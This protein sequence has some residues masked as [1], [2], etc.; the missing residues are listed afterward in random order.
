MRF[1]VLLAGYL[2]SS[3]I[4]TTTSRDTKPSPQAQTNATSYSQIDDDLF[5]VD[6]A[7]PPT[8]EMADRAEQL[9]DRAEQLVLLTC[10]GLMNRYVAEWR[11]KSLACRRIRGSSPVLL[12]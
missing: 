2:L 1:L 7:L 3:V 12:Y 9:A 8:D 5:F 10:A 11:G 6:V 4:A